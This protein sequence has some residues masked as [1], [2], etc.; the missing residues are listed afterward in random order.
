M[1][2]NVEIMTED[3]DKTDTTFED[4]YNSGLYTKVVTH[5]VGVGITKAK[6]TVI[7]NTD[8]LTRNYIKDGNL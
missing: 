6:T 4:K 5:R 7:M 3:K 8:Y 2:N 1:E